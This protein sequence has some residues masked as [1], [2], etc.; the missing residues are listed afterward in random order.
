M[1]LSL[2]EFRI[3][4]ITEILP[5]G[6]Q[7]EVKELIEAAIKLLKYNNVTN[8]SIAGFVEKSLTDLHQYSPLNEEARQ[9]SNIKTA[10]IL[11]NRVS[12]S[13][14]SAVN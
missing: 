10:R 5:A 2:D 14:R 3:A 12:Y 8:Q 11:F 1:T 13:L 9:W 6:S 4:L 7:E